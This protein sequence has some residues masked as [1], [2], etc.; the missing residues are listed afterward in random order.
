M[1]EKDINKTI[2]KI[3]FNNK[4][5][6]EFIIFL[7]CLLIVLNILIYTTNIFNNK[8]LI[9][10]ITILLEIV[11]VIFIILIIINNYKLKKLITNRKDYFNNKIQTQEEN[12]NIDNIIL[13]K[14]KSL[15]IEEIERID[16]FSKDNRIINSNN[17]IEGKYNNLYFK[18]YDIEINDNKDK[19]IGKW[20][21]L[22]TLIK[23]NI[24]TYICN[25]ENFIKD[26]IYPKNIFEEYKD[27]QYKVLTKNNNEIIK[28]LIDIK[29]EL[30]KDV[31]ISIINGNIQILVF[32]DKGINIEE[33]IKQLYSYLEVIYKYKDLLMLKTEEI[34]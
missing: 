16:I 17:L 9:L 18:S 34:L 6:I 2:D 7:S 32:N 3:K 29:E 24:S 28:V 19:Y 21:I 11:F 20:I 26:L 1:K 4:N 12:I 10:L 8:E 25:K 30:N 33:E 31:Y 5:R 27:K 22:D 13:K 15:S 14:D 23:D